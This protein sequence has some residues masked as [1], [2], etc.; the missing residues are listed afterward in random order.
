MVIFS[1]H[2]NKKAFFLAAF[3]FLAGMGI[4]VGTLAVSP[5]FSH[6]EPD[7]EAED[8]PEPMIGR[9]SLVELERW[10]RPP[11]PPRVAVQAGHW[12]ND[13]VPDE[14][15]GLKVNGGATGGGI[16]EREAVLTIAQHMVDLLGQKG[17]A[18]E[19]LPT[20]VPPG[21]VADA[22][23]SIH[24][25][26]SVDTSVSGYKVASPRRD[27]SGVSA[28]LATT[29]DS[30]YGSATGFRKDDNITSRMRGYYAFNWRRYEHAIHPMTPAAIVET[31][32]IT[33]ASDRRVLSR[34]PDKVAQAVAD[35]ILLFLESRGLYNP[36][37]P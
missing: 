20:T 13:E 23:V 27:Y 16:T 2:H 5:S 15:S 19:L 35:G 33:N 21:Y 25:D 14:L 37:T 24:A 22:F 10:T 9:Y 7:F 29:I 18:A 17:I 28:D 30:A 8:L 31:G 3:L 6:S 26:G 11:G 4:A 36:H 34:Q 32:F 12:K 1:V